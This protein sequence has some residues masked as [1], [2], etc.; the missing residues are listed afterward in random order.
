MSDTASVTADPQ[1][2]PGGE[3]GRGTVGPRIRSFRRRAG[4]SQE[5]AA[6]GAGISARALR[7]IE[8]GR[9]R[10]PRA[11]TLRRLA[12]TLGLSDDELA[13]LLAD[14]RTGPPRDTGR[15]SLLILGPLVLRRGRTPVPVVGPMLRRLLGLL[16]LKHPE[17][18]TQQEV[19]D[20]LW[21]SGPPRSHPSLIHTYVS[22]ARRL[23][24]PCG[25]GSAP[26]PTVVRTPT[27]Y[28]LEASRNRIDLGHFDE[29]LAR[30][31]RLPRA[32]EPE[33]L[34]ESLAEALR[35]WR[36]PVL[37]DA[38]PVLR[39]HPAAVA[40]EERRV[41]AALLHADTALL[42][43]RSG[44]AVPVLADLVNA[45]PLH[46]GLHARLILALADSGEQAA[47]LQ[48]FTRL[49]RRL[50]EELGI[51]PGTEVREAHLR[52]LRR[53]PPG[54]RRADPD[55]PA[56][57]APARRE[58]AH[59]TEARRAPA[60]RAEPA[61][62]TPLPAQLPYGAGAFVGR[63]PQVRV[64]DTL[65]A[66]DPARRPRIAV[67]V[68]PPGVGKTALVTHWAHAR[69]EHFT[70]GQL[71]VD[72][73]GH[74][75]L[76]TLRPGDVLAQFLRA[77]GAPPHAL[78]AHPPNEDEA[79]ALYRTLLAGKRL[80]I[81]LDNARDAEQVRPLIPG[82]PGCAVV[83]TSRSRLAGLVSTEGARRIALDVLDPD[84]GCELLGGIAG[85]CNVAA[86]E[87]AA[88]RLVELCGGLPLAIR[89][90]G[91]NLVARD[92]SIAGHCAELAGDGILGRLRVEGDRRSTVR[93]AF[94]LSYR[95][96]PEEAR[97]MFRLL[98]Q[99][100]GPELTVDAAAV[101]A[102]VTPA[103]S[104]AL[105]ARLADAHLVRERAGR[106]GLDVLLRSYARELIGADE[107]HTARRRLVLSR[108]PGPVRHGT[109]RDNCSGSYASSAGSRAQSGGDRKDRRSAP[110]PSAGV[111]HPEASAPS[112]PA[113]GSRTGPSRTVGR[114][115]APS[116]A[117]PREPGVHR[118]E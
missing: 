82:A 115:A 102:G 86:E 33:A 92:A 46:E 38:D 17:P 78:P 30:S 68:G 114:T 96:L 111:G 55:E 15:P 13:D 87:A 93:S 7:D 104:A 27:G 53:Q 26:P 31:E 85:A 98:G 69:R 28:R 83:I 74:S 105:L 44:E 77:L 11:H 32:T 23:L 70:D 8:R 22:Q 103:A 47:A 45:E 3:H 50:D 72:L 57:R 117:E 36:G 12:G 29:L 110:L 100:P 95:T 118:H 6:S 99:L 94:E 84:E 19:T 108:A 64:L 116:R 56:H 18:A 54:P 1:G 21:P 51:E 113:G 59:P 71:F 42:L 61:A 62:T 41:R 76:P 63:R 52:V 90:A 91:A 73:R 97:R 49:R 80:L 79:A 101:L 40:A 89:T 25:P 60:R 4:L 107:A 2:G 34:Y 67:V 109:G 81:V 106:F 112:G 65:V 10:R 88:R 43:R 75:R 24:A 66:S 9:A 14:A 39:R 5:A 20:I 58:P 16:A 37:A 35:C 48:V